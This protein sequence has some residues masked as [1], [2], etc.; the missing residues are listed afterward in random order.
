MTLAAMAAKQN[1]KNE[2]KFK[3]NTFT[4]QFCKEI[5]FEIFPKLLQ[6]NTFNKVI[7]LNVLQ[8]NTAILQIFFRFK[9]TLC[10]TM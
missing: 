3:N 6:S 2:S 5:I 4:K 7:T 1:L 10:F 9:K 8:S